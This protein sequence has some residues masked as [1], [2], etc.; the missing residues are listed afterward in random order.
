VDIY[1]NSWGVPDSGH[2]LNGPGTLTRRILKQEVTEG[3]NGKGSIFV[4]ANGN[5]GYKD[6]CAADGYASSIFTIS[7]GAIGVDGDPSPFDEQCSAKL[8]VV[9][10]TDSAGNETTRTT[11]AGTGCTSE[12]GGTSA[13]TSMV[14]GI[15][16]LAL[17]ANPELT[18]RDVQYLIVYTANPHLTLGNLTRNG[19]GLAVSR[20][21]GFGVMDAEAMVTRARHWIG[22]PPQME[23]HFSPHPNSGQ[24]TLNA[25]FT[26]SLD[27]EGFIHYLEHVVVIISAS[28][29]NQSSRGHIQIKVTSPSGTNSTLLEQ[30]PYDK[31]PGEYRY[32]PFMSV[33]F[34]G[35]NPI[36][37][38]NLAIY[39]DSLANVS[40]VE[41]HFYGVSTTPEAVANIPDQCHSDCRRGCAREGSNFCD[42]CLNLRNASTLECTDDN[43]CTHGYTRCNGYCYDASQ[44]KKLSRSDFQKKEFA[45]LLP[46]TL[47]YDIERADDGISNPIYFPDELPLGCNSS[48]A[49]VYVGTN[50]YFT[51]DGF[52][53]FT[54]FEFTQGNGLSLVAPFFTDIDISHGNGQIKYEIFNDSTTAP[55]DEFVLTEM[56]DV[57]NQNYE[58][59]NFN[60]K[61]ALVALWHDV[62]HYGDYKNVTTQFQGALVTNGERSFA[63]FTYDCNKNFKAH[64]TIGVITGLGVTENHDASYLDDSHTISCSN[65][66]YYFVNVV[67]E[68]SAADDVCPIDT[69]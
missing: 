11:E 35:E 42:S 68:I 20:Q 18:W 65:E 56:S 44:L 28:A 17:E 27:F 60:A 64:A 36:G 12:F 22:V 45:T 15:V 6:D 23:E 34:W 40:E 5:G 31:E 39:T 33:H 59:A 29:I 30:R 50:G 8:V 26:T 19:A 7:V 51:F 24:A 43:M 48:A 47:H 54:P 41:F 9:Y 66:P 58:S 53:G 67:Y 57:I 61:W 14:S 16:A 55:L 13:A 63:V 1:S 37:E 62:P 46:S 69:C 4:F 25:P 38:W 52:T 10:V 2:D 49:N 21:F 3:R 32:W